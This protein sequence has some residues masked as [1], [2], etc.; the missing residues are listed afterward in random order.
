[1]RYLLGLGSNIGNKESN[2]KKSM[3]LLKQ[4]GEIRKISSV[5]E[6]TPVD[7][8]PETENFYNLALEFESPL[9]PQ[10]LLAKIKEVEKVVGRNL[11]LPPYQPR[12]IDIDILMAEDVVLE[13]EELAIP[14]P[15]IEHRAFVLTPLADIAS[16]DTHPRLK[17]T[18]GSLYSQLKSEEKIRKL[19]HIRFH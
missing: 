5:Y 19:E 3:L 17:D 12:E 10:E 9:E 13:S 6:T 15:E 18:I 2:I 8:D 11:D 14:H 16:C 7:M 1:M 4:V